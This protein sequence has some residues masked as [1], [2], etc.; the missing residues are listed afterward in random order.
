[1]PDV[2]IQETTVAQARLLLP[3]LQRQLGQQRNLL[4]TLTGRFPNEADRNTFRLNAFHLPRR[5]PLS[6]PAQL[7]RQRPDVRTAEANLRAA[8]AQIGAALAER[9]PQIT[10][11]GNIGGTRSSMPDL[12]PSGAFWMVAGGVGQRIFDAGTL[13]HRQRAAEEATQQALAQYRSSVL[14]AFQNVGDVLRALQ[15]DAASVEAAAAAERTAARNI[16]LIQRQFAQGQISVPILIV[17]QEAYLQTT[18][19]HIDARASRLANTAALFQALGGGWWN[20]DRPAIAA[21]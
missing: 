3:P 20:V 19:A 15:A 9:L 5:L 1:M 8:N 18:L 7:V 13:Y 10:L 16:E 14:A 4:A 2:V 11:T 17:A 6:L 12:S 21:R